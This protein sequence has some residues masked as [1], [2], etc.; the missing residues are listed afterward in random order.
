[1]SQL[2]IGRTATDVPSTVMGG[3]LAPTHFTTQLPTRNG[4]GLDV[5]ISL[6]TGASDD[7][8]RQRVARARGTRTSAIRRSTQAA[9]EGPR[10]RDSEP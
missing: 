6:H 5:C 7:S 10:L 3:Q 2:N 8:G 9:Y 4:N 1:M